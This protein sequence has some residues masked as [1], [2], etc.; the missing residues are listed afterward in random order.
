MTITVGEE[1]ITYDINSA[2][3]AT[4]RYEVSIRFR[5]GGTD[6]LARVELPVTR[7]QEVTK[8]LITTTLGDWVESNPRA[9]L[10]EYAVLEIAVCRSGSATAYREAVG[11]KRDAPPRHPRRLT[12]IDDTWREPMYE[13]GDVVSV[14]VGG[15][16]SSVYG[17]KVGTIR[18]TS[19]SAETYWIDID[20]V[21]K[22]IP[23]R[24]IIGYAE[25]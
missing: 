13:E 10:I 7:R 14:D 19:G 22:R 8:Q 24:W 1:V 2:E 25:D 17:E 3:E 20:G 11:T 15:P 4:P 23:E 18:G 12:A 16:E 6:D 5:A 21:R 9:T